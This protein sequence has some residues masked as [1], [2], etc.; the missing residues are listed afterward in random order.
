MKKVILT[1]KNFA[2][3]KLKLISMLQHIHAENFSFKPKLKTMSTDFK[4]ILAKWTD[5]ELINFVLDDNDWNDPEAIESAEQEII[6]RGAIE[7]LYDAKI[8]YD[9]KIQIQKDYDSRKVGSF[10]RLFHLIID[11]SAIFIIFYFSFKCIIEPLMGDSSDLSYKIAVA[12]WLSAVYFAYYIFTEFKYQKTLGK[13]ITKT[14]VVKANGKKPQLIDVFRRT[15][16]RFL[17][18]FF[19]NSFLLPDD[20]HDTFTNTAVLKDFARSEKLRTS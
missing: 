7:K 4:D 15:I 18:P 5:D 20:P 16:F 1:A 19:A 3:R 8:E 9:A 6:N 17:F 11:S 14:S 12:I 2:S 10:T 13:F